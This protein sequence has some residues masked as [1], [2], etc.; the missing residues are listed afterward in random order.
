MCNEVR[1]VDSVENVERVTRKKIGDCDSMM[2]S[3]RVEPI[4]TPGVKVTSKND[5][6]VESRSSKKGRREE[7]HIFKIGMGMT[8]KR[9]EDER[10]RGGRR[11]DFEEVDLGRGG[12]GCWREGGKMADRDIRT[13]QNE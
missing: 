10:G 11:I 7:L 8:I 12:E 5:R 2:V 9:T 3:G 1:D 13:N 4:F 6:F